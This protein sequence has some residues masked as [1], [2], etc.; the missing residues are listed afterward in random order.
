MNGGNPAP[1]GAEAARP[2]RVLICEDQAV[3]ALRLRKEV[4]ALGYEVVGE[5]HDGRQAV[6]KA[7]AFRPNVILMDVHMP[8]LNG[9]DATA[10]ITR[11][12]RTAVVMLTAYNEP[13]LVQSAL[14]AG[15]SGYLVKP[16]QSEQ[17]Q[18]A[19]TMALARFQHLLRYEHPAE[20]GQP[21]TSE[22]V[23]PSDRDQALA[24]AA[25]ERAAVTESLAQEL[26]HRLKEERQSA[27]LLAETF[28]CPLPALPGYEV[29]SRYEPAGEAELVGGD[30]FD[31]LNLGPGRTGIVIGDACGKGVSAAAFTA[32]TRYMLRA[33]AAEDPAPGRVLTRLNRA[34][35]AEVPGAV[36]FVTL[37]YG[38]LEHETGNW[39]YANGGHPGPI[40]HAST[41]QCD[42][43][44]TTGPLVGVIPNAYYTEETRTLHPGNTLV[45]FTDGITEAFNGQEMLQVEGVCEVTRKRAAADPAVLAGAIVA[46][47][48]EFDRG[49]A[50][51]DIAVVVLRRSSAGAALPGPTAR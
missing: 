17:L 42:V 50:H 9:I 21:P 15:A 46:C 31:F 38:I 40:L 7:L 34:L 13:A 30:Y 35:N 41:E 24:A 37:I 6:A 10:Q 48:R 33:Y 5:A 14:D 28:L 25:D 26:R 11:E 39:T 47:A 2:V 12:Y 49:I 51:D 27:R 43:L 18:P 20:V 8:H 22:P 44:P 16:V 23:L 1:G 36:M 4:Q 3:T 19:I 45:L 29:A 32:K